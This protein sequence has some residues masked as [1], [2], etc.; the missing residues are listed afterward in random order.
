VVVRGGATDPED[1]GLDGAQLR[2]TLDGSEVG[3]GSQIVLEGLAPG[4]Y[5][6]ALT[7]TDSAGRETTVNRTFTVAPLVIAQ[8]ATA[9]TVDGVC[10]DDAYAGAARVLLAPYDDGGQATV[11]LIG[12]RDALYACFVGMPRTRGTSPG[13]LAGLRIDSDA[14][15]DG[16]PGANDYAFYVDEGGVVTSF[17]GDGNGFVAAA[18]GAAGQIR[19]TPTVWHAELR[20]ESSMLGGWNHVVRLAPAQVWVNGTQDRYFW[21][22]SATVGEPIS[23]ASAVLGAPPQIEQLIPGGAAVGSDGITVT[24]EGSGFADSA[25]ATWHGEVRPTTVISPTQ[26]QVALG[27]ADL[28]APGVYLIGVQNDGNAASGAAPR[29]FLVNNPAPTVLSAALAETELTVKGTDFVAGATIL[30]NGTRLTPARAS[31]AQLQ[32]NLSASRVLEQEFAQ[33]AVHNPGPGGGVSGL[34]P[35][36]A[37]AASHTLYLPWLTK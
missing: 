8:V 12:S 7:A 27:A 4:D 6:L 36:Q 1:G 15:G 16:A 37:G 13:T 9:P 17:V 20:I 32:V 2:W 34:V 19:A 22:H 5:S 21:P 29:A 31:A 30:W 33:V 23:W 25:R 24:I 18:E 26:L 14:S 28:D 3:S 35:V 11:L 10:N